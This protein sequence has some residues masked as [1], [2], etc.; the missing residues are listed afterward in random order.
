[1]PQ[2]RAR[3]PGR[4]VEVDRPLLERD[5]DRQPGQ[6]LRHRRPRELGVARRRASRR[7]RR[8]APLRRRPTPRPSRRSPQ[9]LHGGDTRRVTRAIVPRLSPF[10][11]TVGYTRAVRDGQH[12]YVAGTA[13]VGVYDRRRARL[14][15]LAHYGASRRDGAITRSC[16]G[17]A[18]SARRTSPAHRAHRRLQ[19]DSGRQF[20]RVARPAHRRQLALR[21]LETVDDL[22]GPLGTRHAAW[23]SSAGRARRRQLVF[24]ARHRLSGCTASTASSWQVA[25]VVIGI[26]LVLLGRRFLPAK[27]GDIVPA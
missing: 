5:E 17:S 11:D 19:P 24:R 6:E 21:R 4:L 23:S 8:R 14:V 15:Q 7:R 13:P 3:R 18:S 12:I 22:V 9:R 27:A 2:R 20:D 16:D 10:A 26:P 25:S 1:M